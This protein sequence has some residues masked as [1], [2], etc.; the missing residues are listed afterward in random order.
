MEKNCL[1]L[2]LMFF[3]T[4]AFAKVDRSLLQK[5]SLTF[6]EN[7]GQ[8]TDQYGRPRNDID[9]SMATKDLSIFI[10][11]GEVHYQFNKYTK[12]NTHNADSLF[13]KLGVPV[14]V[15]VDAYR[16]DVALLGANKSAD[17]IF[18]HVSFDV[19]NYYRGNRQMLDAKSGGKI[20]YKNI[21]P[22]I[23]WVLYIHDNGLK[24]DF[25]LHA[26]A[27]PNKIKLKYNGATSLR[28]EG[29]ALRASTPLG[30]ITEQKPYAY[31]LKDKKSV[32]CQFTLHNN[33]LSFATD[34]YN[35]VL[36]IDPGIVWA[37][38][39]GGTESDGISDIAVDSA[40]F[41][42]MTGITSS[43]NVATL[44]AHQNVFSGSFGDAFL[45]KFDS[46]GV[47][48]WATYFGSSASDAPI[49]FTV[50]RTVSCGNIGEIYIAG[51]TTCKDIA[52]PT[53]FQTGYAGGVSSIFPSDAFLAKF[54]NSGILQ[55]AT[56]YGGEADDVA[57]AL[58][59]DEDN[60]IYMVGY[61]GSN[62]LATPNGHQPAYGGN[63]DGFI[64]KFNASG[65]RQWA[66]YYGGEEYDGVRAVDVDNQGNV[67]IGGTTVSTSGISTQGAHQPT[68]KATDEGFV[69]KITA[70][71][72]R[73][74]GTYY[75][76]I[77]GDYVTGL[78]CDGDSN[79]YVTGCTA[80]IEGIGTPE[81]HQPDFV[82]LN[83]S[84]PDLFLVKFGADGRRK[85]GTYF[86]GDYNET[87]FL[88]HNIA[89]D[90]NGNVYISGLTMSNSLLGPYI[91]TT[92]SHQDTLATGEGATNAVLAQFTSSGR[93][94]WATYYGGGGETAAFT[95]CD[96][97]G[98]V[99]LAGATSSLNH[100][101][102]AGSFMPAIGGGEE[103][104]LVRFTPVDL[105]LQ[106]MFVPKADTICI[107][108]TP[109][110][111]S[112]RN[113]GRRNEA[114]TIIVHSSYTG[115]ASGS[116]T[117]RHTRGLGVGATDTV[118]LANMDFSVVGTYNFKAWLEY[119]RD[120]SSKI[121]DT[122]EFSVTVIDASS[123][124]GIDISSSG[125]TTHTFSATDEKNIVDYHWDFGDGNTDNTAH[126]SHSYANSGSY[127]VT[128]IASNDCGSDTVSTMLQAIGTGIGILNQY[129][130]VSIYP[131]PVHDQL[132][133]KDNG[134]NG[135]YS[136]S[137]F[138]GYGQ[139]A[140]KGSI[141][142]NRINVSFLPPGVYV[143]FLNDG[144]GKNHQFQFAKF[145][146]ISR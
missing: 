67:Y 16:L 44:G 1:L 113:N 75:G 109:V 8:I 88:N 18:E 118:M 86:G 32:Q 122:L 6:R 124:S 83:W 111:L 146:F 31:Q 135:M 64:A 10:G 106:E 85:W 99:Y 5:Q 114:D 71:G 62:H 34:N 58:A 66:T 92:G 63:S 68:L 141:V 119:T 129:Q 41:I 128:L 133:I 15:Q 23:D 4:L 19:A 116:I 77:Q 89:C 103:G 40:G 132:F 138:N 59:C 37:T 29:G 97:F 57:T 145:C 70:D 95:A 74:W 55:W 30:S 136:F 96:L 104:F 28:L 140:I 91:A 142:D 21:Y 144:K 49:S 42:Y 52:T 36:V 60:N 25:I 93:R 117:R 11:N 48:H 78:A 84:Y 51:F 100:I 24:Y 27:D 121:N 69:A 61:T 115:P 79:I 56:Y 94:V 2:L 13:K 22:N 9:F 35:D 47:R 134:T 53:A 105:K 33:I 107:G 143:L 26:G 43:D 125:I 98:N 50:G 126:P 17:I 101:A 131:N 90:E 87:S 38:Y 39:F 130:S 20:T 123:V 81:T 102:T 65:A 7:K 108:T 112:I 3:H 45:A 76:D 127:V 72:S 54:N 14:P 46:L 80:S 120:D 73:V 139:C 110:V 82:F 137:I 12:S